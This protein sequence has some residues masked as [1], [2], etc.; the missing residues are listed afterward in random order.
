MIQF[1]LLPDVKLE[2]LRTSRIKRTVMVIAAITGSVALAVFIMLLVSVRVLQ[3][4]HLNN[5]NKQVKKSVSDLK[6]V[7]DI[8]KILTIQNQLN[9]LPGLHDQK[10][11]TSRLFGY[12]TQV[13]PAK[14][15]ITNLEVDFSDAK[16]MKIEGISDSLNTVNKFVDTIKFTEFSIKY[17]EDEQKRT[18]VLEVSY[19]ST[20]R[21][22]VCRAFSSVVLTTFN[23]TDK[24]V[25]FEINLVFDPLIFDSKNTVTLN[26]PKIITTRSELEKPTALFQDTPK[27][28]GTTR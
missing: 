11:V 10:P 6:A 12:L 22:Q 15:N 17:K 20:T 21:V 19:D 14:A 1:N 18:C 4:N 28:D 13:T 5:L 8:N 3:K 7:P 9:S 16:T 25:K 24:G 27:T 23:L 26:V 2:Y